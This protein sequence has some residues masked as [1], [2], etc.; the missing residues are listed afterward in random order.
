AA[1]IN[2]EQITTVAGRLQRTLRPEPRPGPGTTRRERG[3]GQGRQRSVR[4][5]IE[6]GDRVSTRRVVI[7]VDVP[8][9][10]RRGGTSR[11][12]QETGEHECEQRRGKRPACSQA[13]CF[14][15]LATGCLSPCRP[16]LETQG[17]V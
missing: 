15:F 12:R 7:D 8:H 1:S 6:P 14:S 10:L 9:H 3:A 13:H 11:C 2:R 5:T 16:V 17:C 4:V